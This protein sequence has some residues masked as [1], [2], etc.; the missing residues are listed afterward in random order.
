[1]V[2]QAERVREF[3]RAGVRMK[4]ILAVVGVAVGLV[5]AAPV[6]GEAVMVVYLLLQGGK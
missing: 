1:M 6:L 4:G 3:G 5:L 2:Q